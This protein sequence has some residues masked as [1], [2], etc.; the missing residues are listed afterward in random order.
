MS[1]R[2]VPLAEFELLVLLAALSLGPDEAYTVSIAEQIAA[3]TGRRVRRANVYTT[4]QRLESKR[5][6]TT[7]FGEARPER[8]GKPRRLVDVRPAG[9][10]AVRAATSA[11]RALSGGIGN[12]IGER[13]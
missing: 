8:G 4:L 13:E 3:K 1:P 12:I 2:A 7:R 9:V 6:I 10:A 5:L 11:I